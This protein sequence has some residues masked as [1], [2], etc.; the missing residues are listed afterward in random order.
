M[1]EYSTGA[2]ASDAY[3]GYFGDRTS[4]TEKA[5]AL[6]LGDLD[7]VESRTRPT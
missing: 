5:L 6:A 3:G 2:E 4:A 1:S 7:G